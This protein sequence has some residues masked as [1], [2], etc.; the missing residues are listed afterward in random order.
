MTLPPWNQDGRWGRGTEWGRVGWVTGFHNQVVYGGASERWQTVFLDAP[1]PGPA[2]TNLVY[3]LQLRKP[4]SPY[5]R[6]RLKKSPR[7]GGQVWARH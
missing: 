2:T 3:W 1:P 7:L 6:F 5:A 4:A